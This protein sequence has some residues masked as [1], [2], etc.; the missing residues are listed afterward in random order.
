MGINLTMYLMEFLSQI[1]LMVTKVKLPSQNQI[2][3][4][5]SQSEYKLDL[6]IEYVEYIPGNAI[7][8]IS[9]PTSS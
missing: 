4:S 5:P 8:H 2:T 7:G 9:D 1:Q 6:L 3:I